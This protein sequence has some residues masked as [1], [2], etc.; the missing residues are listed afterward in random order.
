MQTYVNVTR[1]LA[2]SSNQFIIQ[3][4]SFF[5]IYLSIF[6]FTIRFDNLVSISSPPFLWNEFNE[7]IYKLA[8]TIP[9]FFM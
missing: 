3:I 5:Q 6:S 7:E 9:R 4:S 1:F 2:A 8:S